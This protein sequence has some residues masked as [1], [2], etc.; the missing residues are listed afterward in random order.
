M[1]INKVIG[2]FRMDGCEWKAVHALDGTL[3]LVENFH[4]HWY[5]RVCKDDDYEPLRLNGKITLKKFYHI[6]HAAVMGTGLQVPAGKYDIRE[7]D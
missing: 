6:A 4:T 1:K 2:R 3:R 5:I 7:V